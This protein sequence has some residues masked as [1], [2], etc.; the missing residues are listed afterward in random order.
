MEGGGGVQKHQIL[1]AEYLKSD[2]SAEV[3]WLIIAHKQSMLELDK[4]LLMHFFTM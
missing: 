1:P 3:E 4:A 2:S